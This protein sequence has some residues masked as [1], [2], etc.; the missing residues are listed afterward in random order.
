[1]AYRNFDEFMIRLEVEDALYRQPATHP[2][3]LP[4]AISGR[5]EAIW[6]EPSADI[7]FPLVLYPFA[8]AQRM[9]WALGL[10]NLQAL[11][12]RLTHL[13]EMP[14]AQGT[15]SGNGLLARA[16]E[17]VSLLHT[18]G[19]PSR[20]DRE[21]QAQA[22]VV[23]GLPDLRR[24]PTLCGAAGEALLCGVQVLVSDHDGT[25]QRV[26][27]RDGLLQTSST[28]TFHE[29]IPGL[30]GRSPAAL[31]FG[32]DPAQIW[33]AGVPLPGS[34]D[35]YLLAGWVRRRA[36]RFVPCLTHA[37][38]IPADAEV[39]I[40]GWLHHADGQAC[41]EAARLTHRRDAVIPAL[42]PADHQWMTKAAERLLLPLIRLLLDNVVDMSIADDTAI[43]A[44]TGQP[45]RALH[46]LWSTE[47]TQA[48]RTLIVVDAA[49]NPHDGD[50]VAAALATHVD[51]TQDVLVVVDDKGQRKI[52]IDATA[53]HRS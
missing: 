32:G 21:T 6:V 46:G 10:D 16:G 3:E 17:F 9:A 26:Y 44:V 53:R 40:E 1:M 51:W 31:V 23:D 2:A 52:G 41:F 36:V 50:A 22:V 37:V 8:S 27:L 34:L 33:A 25:A 7:D 47:L 15:A 29:A 14:G 48:C 18:I 4:R 28:V 12:D 49:V 38:K 5:A 45:R 30:N 43:I 19:A 39:V 20:R 42:L 35:P 11:T 13:L 24:L